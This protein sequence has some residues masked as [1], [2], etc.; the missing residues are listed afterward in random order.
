[1]NA[2]EYETVLRAHTE[3][4]FTSAIHARLSVQLATI[5]TR[6]RKKARKNLLDFE[7]K[8]DATAALGVLSSWLF[9]YNT[10]E[11][12]MLFAAVIVCLMG[13]MYEANVNSAFYPGA[14]DGVTGV[15]MFTVVVAIVYYFAMLF[16]EIV[17][18]YNEDVRRTQMAKAAKA[19]GVAAN[20]KKETDKAEAAGHHVSREGR[21][22]G[23]NGTLEL[24]NVENAVNPMFATTDGRALSPSMAGG[25]SSSAMEAVV[26][27]RSPPPPELWPIFQQ[28]F[29][30]QVESLR[31]AQAKIMELQHAAMLAEAMSSG[32]PAKT[33]GEPKRKTE[34]QPRSSAAVVMSGFSRP[35]SA[36]L[37]SQAQG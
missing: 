31:V 28:Q 35:K 7:G 17:I 33:T 37:K 10:I 21:L 1:M 29:R 13:I 26:S 5:E 4:A 34:F 19:A 22:V 23:E 9:N 6:G 2:A 27:S 16:T 36:S 18:L 32:P 14:L 12:L 25:G 8:I 11:Q 3:S 20:R 24:G 30:E 15:V